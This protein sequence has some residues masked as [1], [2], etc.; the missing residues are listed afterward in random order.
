MSRI[1]AY[2]TKMPT[3]K[4]RRFS[5]DPDATPTLQKLFGPNIEARDLSI[6]LGMPSHCDFVVFESCG[7]HEVLMGAASLKT[8][9]QA[10]MFFGDNPSPDLS[11]LRKKLPASALDR[12]RRTLA[13]ES[14]LGGVT[15]FGHLDAMRK[16]TENPIR[17]EK[18]QAKK[19]TSRLV[20][21]LERKWIQISNLDIVFGPSPATVTSMV[22][23]YGLTRALMR[24]FPLNCDAPCA[25]SSDGLSSLFRA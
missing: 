7:R 11:K 5:I 12:I 2:C 14:T 6:K 9:F 3:T 19:T 8:N 22:T 25:R 23:S 21:I 16:N 1:G 10:L 24:G 18:G 15:K 20:S 4:N 13:L 17:R